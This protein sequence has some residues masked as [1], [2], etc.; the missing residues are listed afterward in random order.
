MCTHTY[1]LCIPIPYSYLV[2]ILMLRRLQAFPIIPSPSIFIY[3]CRLIYASVCA[4]VCASVRECKRVG[5]SGRQ[6]VFDIPS[7][8]HLHISSIDTYSLLIVYV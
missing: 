1:I 6:I 3:S 5:L 7:H 4:S 8:S 2:A